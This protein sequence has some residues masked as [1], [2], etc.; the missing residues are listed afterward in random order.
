MLFSVFLWGISM[1]LKM[2][3][4]AVLARVLGAHSWLTVNQN[5]VYFTCFQVCRCIFQVVISDPMRIIRKQNG[6]E[7]KK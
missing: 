4:G 5:I 7:E 2:I 3:L 6:Y 1:G